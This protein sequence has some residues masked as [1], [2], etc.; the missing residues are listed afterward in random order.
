MH[1]WAVR[2]RVKH[3]REEER[4]YGFLR[5]FSVSLEK[6]KI[7]G[8]TQSHILTREEILSFYYSALSHLGHF[9]RKD[10]NDY[11]VA[12]GLRYTPVPLDTIP[13]SFRGFL[14]FFFLRLIVFIHHHLELTKIPKGVTK[15]LYKNINLITLLDIL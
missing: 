3:I 15:F 12:R 8:G 2:L 13:F 4:E 14:I 1:F 9:C 7:F 6:E 11:L 10:K 5:G